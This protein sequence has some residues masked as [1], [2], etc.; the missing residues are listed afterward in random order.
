M[1]IF[2]LPGTLHCDNFGDVAML[3]VALVRLKKSGRRRRYMF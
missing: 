2:V 1:N 3:Q